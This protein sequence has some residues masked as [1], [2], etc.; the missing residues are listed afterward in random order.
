MKHLWCILLIVAGCSVQDI[1][2]AHKG[3]MFQKTG[4]LAFYSGGKGFDGPVLSP[5][6][7][8]LGVYPEVRMVDCATRTIKEPLTSMTRDGVQF[9]ADI[10]VSFSANCAD[11]AAV[12]ALLNNLSPMGK[13]D[14]TSAPQTTGAGQGPVDDRDPTEPNPELTVTSRQVYQTYIR[15]AI[16]EAARQAISSY[17]ANDLNAHREELFKQINEK[18]L[19]DLG[20]DPKVRLV[21]I[22]S[23]NLSNFKLPDE[24]ANAA[25]DRATQ[26]VLRDKSTA[27]QERIK[28]ETETVKLTIAQRKAEGEAEAA[29]IDAVGAALHR[30]PEYYLR[31]IYFYAA[32]KGGSVVL[33]TN[34]NVILQMTPHK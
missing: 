24:L 26:Q 22:N 6:T 15:P 28:V 13:T 11:D 33:P 2:Q 16:G 19:S 4:L 32:E 7:Y 8:Y 17:N 31:D 12:Q 10:Y 9:A 21:T 30:N 18:L 14:P 34:P 25:A 27:E 3:R 1:P 29:K 20:K 5:G 23:L